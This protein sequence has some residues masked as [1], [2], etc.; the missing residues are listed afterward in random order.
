MPE[1]GLY[2]TWLHWIPK[3]PLVSGHVSMAI[4]GSR[5][6]RLALKKK[7]KSGP[8]RRS[9]SLFSKVDLPVFSFSLLPK[10][11]SFSPLSRLSCVH[12]SRRRA[13]RWVSILLQHAILGLTQVVKVL[14][15]LAAPPASTM[16]LPVFFFLVHTSTFQLL[17]KPWSQVSSLLPP[18]SCLQFLS[19]IGFSNPSARRFF[20]ECC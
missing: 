5:C 8:K 3:Q 7:R 1:A 14:P 9:I 17:G 13:I 20:I 6:G 18:G 19:R 16:V 4:P 15:A 11:V 10:C 2:A 12:L